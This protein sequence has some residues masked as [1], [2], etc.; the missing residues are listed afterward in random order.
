MPIERRMMHMERRKP[1]G[2]ALAVIAAVALLMP[3]DVMGAGVAKAFADSPCFSQKGAGAS[4]GCEQLARQVS[5]D[6][7]TVRKLGEQL[8]QERRF[9]DAVA[10]YQVALAVHPDH[11]DLLQ[12]LIRARAQA[13]AVQ[14]LAT[15]E[16]RQQTTAAAA[17]KAADAP[18]QAATAGPAATQALA[19]RVPPPGAERLAA[20]SSP[21]A[22]PSVPPSSVAAA[23]PRA[24][25][26]APRD[27]RY[28]AL[29]I[30]NEQYVD[31]ER[32]RTPLADVRA[33]AD[34]LTRQY[35][36]KVT[37]LANA[38]RYQIVSALSRLRQE[39]TERDNVLIYYAGHGYLDDTTSRGYWLPVDAEHDNLGNWLSTSDITDVLAGLQA[40]HALILADSCFSGTLLRS[41]LNV[42]IDER[43]SMLHKLSSRRSRSIMTSGGLEP[44]VDN[45]GGRHSV[46]AKALLEALRDNRQRLEAARL[47]MQIRD[48]VSVN[49]TQTPQYGPLR[50]AGHEGGDFIFE[51]R[52]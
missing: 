15:P 30:G 14:L 43:Q 8:E 28:L 25:P 29:V 2:A 12:R 27:G 33:I 23:L 32:L 7:G 10:T 39:A 26:E 38:T 17:P 21:P 16:Q 4:Q 46:F 31:F 37:T 44:V 11:R 3:L 51:R 6:I 47:F 19:A 40:K 50:N 18:A 24:A 42:S 35:G 52:D 5:H 41:A 22:A 49:A 20:A 45:G 48:R 36:F 34:V 9:A 1:I 13:R